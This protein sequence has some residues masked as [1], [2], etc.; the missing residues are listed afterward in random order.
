MKFNV[1]RHGAAV[2]VAG[3]A[4][5]AAI[6]G[7]PVANAELYYGS[8]AYAPNGSYGR[9]WDYPTRES[10]ITNAIYA[11]GWTSCKT[12]TTFTECGAVA[13]NSE[14]FQGGSGRTLI[15]AQNAALAQLRGGGGWIATWACN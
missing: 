11:C 9:A 8:I 5:S 1:R 10:A 4:V 2:A 12:L 7:T 14:R 15:E 3:M 6:V 13:E